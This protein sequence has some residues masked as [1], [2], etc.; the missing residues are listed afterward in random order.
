LPTFKKTKTKRSGATRSFGAKKIGAKSPMLVTLRSVC[1]RKKC[2]ICKTT[3]NPQ[4]T[5]LFY[6][7]FNF[8]LVF[9]FFFQSK[10]IKKLESAS[11]PVVVIGPSI[12]VMVSWIVVRL[13][14]APLV[15]VTMVMW[16]RR[17]VVAMQMVAIP[18]LNV[19]LLCWLFVG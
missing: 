18:L 3:Y 7:L 9:C 2:G 6:F 5:S 1:P 19:L 17:T 15:V 12:I 10:R 13:I 4:C 8:S 16:R 14:P 11:S